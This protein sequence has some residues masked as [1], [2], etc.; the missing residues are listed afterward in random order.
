[1]KL[2][3]ERALYGIKL[4]DSIDYYIN[5]NKKKLNENEL[6]INMKKLIYHDIAYSTLINSKIG[7]WY[8]EHNEF[9]TAIKYYRRVIRTYK[10]IEERGIAYEEI[11]KI[12]AYS[13]LGSCYLDIGEYN[14]SVENFR[15]SIY[16]LTTTDCILSHNE[17]E[18][19][20]RLTQC[21]MG[22]SD[23][24]YCLKEYVESIN[25]YNYFLY[26]IQ[27]HN[28]LY[29]PE[30]MK[31]T[32]LRLKESYN[33]NDIIEHDLIIKEAIRQCEYYIMNKKKYHNVSQIL[34]N[35]KEIVNSFDESIINE[36]YD[37]NILKNRA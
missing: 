25:Y 30:D 36:N 22:I 24:Y 11:N 19:I 5:Q 18:K 15:Q 12:V 9:E 31:L 8:I 21:I 23:A 32:L 33:K 16:L 14:K 10:Y 17:L 20:C 34:N 4:L 28:M 3:N 37:L 6:N 35:I 29:T 27:K 2:D 13:K 26:I 7:E 1:L